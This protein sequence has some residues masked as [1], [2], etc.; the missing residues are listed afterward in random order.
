MQRHGGKAVF[1][2]RFVA[3]LRFTAAWLAGLGR[4]TWWRFLFWNAAGG[5][6]WAVGVSLLA[7][8][9]GKAA[10]DAIARYGALGAAGLVVLLILGWL[11]L[12]FAKKR[13]ESRL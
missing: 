9:G 6:A 13:I 5:I 12:H 2:G 11:G 3:I 7:F 10:A 8:Y 4:M 1:F